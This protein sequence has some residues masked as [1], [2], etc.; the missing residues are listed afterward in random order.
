MKTTCLECCRQHW[1][2][3]NLKNINLRS[4]FSG[5]LTR[6]N[7][8]MLPNLIA[9]DLVWNNLSGKFPESIYSCNKLIALWL[10]VNKFH[11][12]LSERISNLKSLSFLSHGKSSLTNITRTL[13]ILG[14]CGNLTTL[15]IG[16]NFMC[17]ANAR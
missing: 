14:S 4:R 11:G 6:V 10:G 8:S 13:Q 1:G 3:T 12:Q 15:I 5:E 17:E 9:L 2:C 16:Y 7:F